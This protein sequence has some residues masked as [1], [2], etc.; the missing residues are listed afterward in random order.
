MITGNATV[1]APSRNCAAGGRF[2]SA[3]IAPRKAKMMTSATKMITGISQGGRGGGSM[4]DTTAP[5]SSSDHGVASR[6][7][8]SGCAFAL[9]NA[10]RSPRCRAPAYWQRKE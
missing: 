2:A 5:C 6:N 10:V 8:L 9:A 7:G 4:V 1:V 3:P